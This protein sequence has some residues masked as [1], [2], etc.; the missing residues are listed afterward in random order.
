LFDTIDT[1]F[2]EHLSI[3]GILNQAKKNST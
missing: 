1:K 2:L 3:D